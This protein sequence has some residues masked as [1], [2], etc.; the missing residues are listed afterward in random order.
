MEEK[1][2]VLLNFQS[3]PFCLT[4]KNHFRNDFE[5]LTLFSSMKFK[6]FIATRTT[7]NT[8]ERKISNC[9]HKK[10]DVSMNAFTK[11]RFRILLDGKFYS[12]RDEGT[13]YSAMFDFLIIRL[14]LIK[15]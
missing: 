10:C 13:N 12:K 4:I 7:Q 9:T 15:K 11:Q 14:L 6:E 5:F 3:Y 2:L 1:Y 8:H